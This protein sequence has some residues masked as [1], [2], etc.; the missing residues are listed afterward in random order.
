M[1]DYD[2]FGPYTIYECLGAGGMASV[3][4]ASVDLG[5]GV[6]R[7]VAL[8][9]LLPQLADDQQFVEGF[10]REAKLAANLHHPNIAK[11]LELGRIKRT[12]YI[13]MELI[14]GHSLAS[15]L[16]KARLANQQAPIG[17]VV[18]IMIELCDVLD[19]VANCTD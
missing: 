3:H 10:I 19:Y 6:K 7:D 12:Y 17:V 14:H 9:R 13:A 4:H 16:K 2:R 5:E 1:A 11:I 8:K 15:I 18:S